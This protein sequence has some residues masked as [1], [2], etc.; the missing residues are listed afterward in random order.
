VSPGIHL[1][2]EDYEHLFTRE[3]RNTGR[4]RGTTANEAKKGENQINRPKKKKKKHLSGYPDHY[5]ERKGLE[6]D[7]LNVWGEDELQIARYD[8]QHLRG[9]RSRR[10]ANKIRACGR[11]DE[12]DFFC[13][14]T[15]DTCHD[16]R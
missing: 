1:K 10:E 9:E 14:L 12:W 15:P 8:T 6:T 2:T 13:Q 16:D 5:T 7:S 3:G 4:R 11:G